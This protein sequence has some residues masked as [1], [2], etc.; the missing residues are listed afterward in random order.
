M[1]QAAGI[2]A[3]LFVCGILIAMGEARRRRENLLWSEQA[4]LEEAV[5]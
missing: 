5:Q 4:E 2:V 1:R 3:F